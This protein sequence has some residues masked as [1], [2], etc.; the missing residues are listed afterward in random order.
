MR[1]GERKKNKNQDRQLAYCCLLITTCPLQASTTGTYT[2]RAELWLAH[3]VAGSVC[4]YLVKLS[5]ILKIGKDLLLFHTAGKMAKLI[6]QKRSWSKDK[7]KKR[8]TKK[9]KKNSS[10][11]PNVPGFVGVRLLLDWFSSREEVIFF[12][13]QVSHHFSQMHIKS[14]TELFLQPWREIASLSNLMRWDLDLYILMMSSLIH[15]VTEK[16]DWIVLD[17]FKIKHFHLN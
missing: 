2:S 5:G 1:R 4:C 10:V 3:I 17:C 15:W 16:M 12:G 14:V 8:T 7:K 6:S 13:K 9:K 11:A